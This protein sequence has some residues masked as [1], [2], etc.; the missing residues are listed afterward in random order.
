MSTW[1]IA[2]LTLFCLGLLW[3]AASVRKQLQELL[4]ALKT[5]RAGE[6]RKVFVKHKGIASEIGLEVNQ[7]VESCRSDL[8]ELKK[9]EQANKELL[10]SLSH[11]VRTPLTSLLGYLDALESGIVSGEEKEQYIKTA[12]KKAYDLKE[13]VDNLFTWFKIGSKE[14]Q[15]CPRPVDVNELTKEILI[16]W[17]PV[18]EQKDIIPASRIAEE[19]CIVELDPAAY[20]RMVSNLI[21]NAVDHGNCK[22]LALIVKRQE[23]GVSI[24]IQDDGKGIAPEQLPNIFDRLYKCDSARGG[25]G[26]GLGLCIVKELTERHGGTITAESFAG[27]DTKFTICLPV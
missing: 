16:D 23:R 10:T 7:L 5:L 21:Q 25:R 20:T 13:F 8:A 12:R 6:N 27:E 15:L 17:L 11:D 1:I 19:E 4:T 3:Y 18:L 26:S 2:V 24:T 9:M 22:R 14:M